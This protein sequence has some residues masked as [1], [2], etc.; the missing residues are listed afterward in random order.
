MRVEIKRFNSINE[1]IQ[2]LRNEISASARVVI[3][4]S[5]GYLEGGGKLSREVSEI[6]RFYYGGKEV[7]Q[8]RIIY[9]Q[10]NTTRRTIIGE[11]ISYL[12]HKINILKNTV[13]ALEEIDVDGPIIVL[14][15][16][17]L[18]LVIIQIR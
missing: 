17:S 12:Q 8:S 2:R 9:K 3:S 16:D 5:Q 1:L 6:L 18:P 13:E 14:L 4:L 15:I 7:F 11:A 10:S